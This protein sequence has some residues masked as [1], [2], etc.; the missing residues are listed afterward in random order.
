MIKC[1]VCNS[2]YNKGEEVV[3]VLGN[4]YY[5]LAYVCMDCVNDYI[6]KYGITD[7]EVES[8]EISFIPTIVE[9]DAWL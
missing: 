6:N 5:H 1:D 9:V 4:D 3:K 7:E 2:V 8:T